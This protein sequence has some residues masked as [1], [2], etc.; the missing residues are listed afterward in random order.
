M[1]G[2]I[3]LRFCPLFTHAFFCC[4]I[5][6]AFYVYLLIDAF[7]KESAD[8]PGDERRMSDSGV[9]FLLSIPFLLIFLVGCHSMYL[10]N[11]YYDELKARKTER[12]E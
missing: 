4:S 10:L 6:G 2:T 12:K 3:T 11:I 8:N 5:L 9:L 7:F 1:Y